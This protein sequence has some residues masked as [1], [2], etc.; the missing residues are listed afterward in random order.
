MPFLVKGEDEF[1]LTYTAPDSIGRDTLWVA[2]ANPSRGWKF[3]IIALIEKPIEAVQ[4]KP[5]LFPPKA[6][7]KSAPLEDLV[8]KPLTDYEQA[9]LDYEPWIRGIAIGLLTLLFWL[10]LQWRERRRRKLIAE[11]DDAAKPP[12]VWNITIDN[13]NPIR[14]NETF[15]QT[16]QRLRSRVTD[17]F[18]RLDIPQTIQATID[19]AG[20]PDFRFRQQ[21]RPPEYLMLIDRHSAAN[22]RARLYD[23]LYQML[24]EN[25][26]FVERYFYRGDLRLLWN[27]K[28]PDGIALKT[29]QNQYASSRLLIMGTGYQLLSPSGKLARWA[30]GFEQWKERSILSP[31]PLNSWG[32][33]ERTLEEHF[34]LLPAS[35]QGFNMLIEQ[36]D[37]GEDADPQGW[38]QKITDAQTE[39]LQ[40]EGSLIESLQV[41][42]PKPLFDWI[43]ACAVYP[44]LHWD[45]TRLLGQALATPDEPLVTL[46]NLA[47]LNRL[48]W[49]VDG[50]MPLAVRALLR[51][52]LERE[53]PALLLKVQKALHA[54]LQH[55]KPPKDSVAWQEHQMTMAFNEWL[56][57]KDQARKK[58]LE[59]Q[60]ASLICLR[61]G[62]RF[63][64]HK[65]PKTRAYTPGLCSA[66]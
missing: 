24:M 54:L 30:Q 46:D 6:R 3:L 41:A 43:A 56:F 25:E 66:R 18:Y 35:L 2:V 42:Y 50:K 65:T 14:L 47:Q 1:C 39:S 7:P 12:Y 52:Y 63:Y 61:C 19:K 49:F 60:I 48:P 55:N 21:T 53:E 22:H 32:A 8:A 15:N 16:L 62:A 51:D 13:L 29:I 4:S 10:L 31:R 44:S 20:M 17:D 26:V 38:R 37:A 9:F 59:A 40:L 5:Q 27:E 23:Y 11:V 64:S 33:R 57:I 28:H 45:L 58:E 36:L 34:I